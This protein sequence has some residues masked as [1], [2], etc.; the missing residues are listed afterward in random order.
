MTTY[1]LRDA[2]SGE[3]LGEWTDDGRTFGRTGTP[4]AQRSAAAAARRAAIREG[5][6]VLLTG[7]GMRER[8]YTPAHARRNLSRPYRERADCGHWAFPPSG[9]GP[10]ELCRQCRLRTPHPARIAALRES[11]ARRREA[12]EVSDDAA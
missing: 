5:R 2:D 9:D 6:Q 11:N 8:L 1:T 7:P 12:A 3:L 4:L 10:A